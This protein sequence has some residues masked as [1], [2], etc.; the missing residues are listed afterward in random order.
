M[1]D[2]QVNPRQLKIVTYLYLH[3]LS[4]RADIAAAIDQGKNS[5]ITIIR[6]LNLLQQHRW[7]I[8]VA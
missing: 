1:N 4:S 6:D 8:Q 5:R 7:I 2:T 3:P